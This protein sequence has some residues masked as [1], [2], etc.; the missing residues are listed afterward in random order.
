M[1]YTQNYNFKK[2]EDDDIYDIANENDNMDSIDFSLKDT[3]D[4]VAAR[5]Q[6]TVTNVTTQLNNALSTVSTQLQNTLNTVEQKVADLTTYVNTKVASVVD[7]IEEL[8]S[9]KVDEKMADHKTDYNNPHQ[10]TLSQVLGS[11]SSGVVPVA[12]GGTGITSSPSILTNLASTSAASVF[13]TSPRPGVTGILPVA[14][15]GVGR[16]A[17][18]TTSTDYEYRAIKIQTTVPTSVSSGCIILV[19]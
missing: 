12:N 13:Q 14:N 16:S 8:V 4:T 17:K 18:T 15:G 11:G 7:K 6:Q 3:L 1:Q 10:V 5:L 2:P 9:S 19:Y